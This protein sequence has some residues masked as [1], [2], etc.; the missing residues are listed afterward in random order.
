MPQRSTFNFVIT[1][2]RTAYNT[3]R[4]HTVYMQY[5]T[6]Y[7]HNK[8]YTGTGRASCNFVLDFL[9]YGCYG[10]K[11]EDINWELKPTQPTLKV[12]PEYVEKTMSA[13]GYQLHERPQGTLSCKQ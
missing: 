13:L 2:P 12:L 8:I 3:H 1:S 11:R 4:Y 5:K 9:I 6:Q 10:C 7:T